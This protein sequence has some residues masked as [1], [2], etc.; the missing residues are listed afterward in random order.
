MPI[1]E[2]IQPKRRCRFCAAPLEHIFADLGTS[3]LA[4]SYLLPEQLLQPESYYPLVAYICDSCYL[5]QLEELSS[6]GDIF[7]DYAYYSSFSDSW[8]E[9]AR[10]FSEQAIKDLKLNEGSLV[11]EIGS[12]D[13]YLLKYFREAGVNVLGIEPAANVAKVSEEK[14]IETVVKFFNDALAEELSTQGKRADLIIANN[15]LAHIPQTNDLMRGF[16][17]LLKPGGTISIETPHLLPLIEENQFDTIYHEHYSYFSL[18]TLDQIFRAHQLIIYDLQ[19]LPTHGGSLRLA[20]GHLEEY[21]GKVSDAVK[22]VLAE[23][24]RKGFKEINY[25]ES[26][27][28]KVK[29]VK[30]NLLKGLIEIKETGKVIAAYGAP[31]KGNTLLNYLG[32]GTDFIEYTVDRN[33]HKQGCFLPGSRI[34]VYSPEII[35]QTKPDYLLILP[36][37]LK[38]EI[39]EQMAMISNWGGRFVIPIPD[40]RII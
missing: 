19:L 5:V 34:P 18:T 22:Q 31:A 10:I 39:M 2:N 30:R 4:N 29:Q 40:F 20:I 23:E 11:I 17:R 16:K 6:P 26:F 37:N 8:L 7:S 36:W 9:H 27:D 32:I 28:C 35:T 21:Q 13:G 1:K 12:N 15:V 24:E 3:P 33:P 25:Y 14:G 38:D